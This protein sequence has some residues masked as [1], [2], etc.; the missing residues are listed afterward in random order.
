MYSEGSAW[1]IYI[2]NL[3]YLQV[4]PFVWLNNLGLFYF[5]QLG[6]ALGF[7]I[8]VMVVRNRKEED[9]I[10]LIGNDLFHMFLGVAIA[11]TILVITILIGEPNIKSH[12]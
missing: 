12:N 8:P 10:H 9:K 4:L 6:V 5:S 1:Q 7:V 2:C 3:I 11:T